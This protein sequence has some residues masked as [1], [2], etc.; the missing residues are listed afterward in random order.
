M[1]SMKVLLAAAVLGSFSFAGVAAEQVSFTPADQQQSGVV[2]A[3]GSTTLTS[4]ESQLSGK[5]TPAGAKS[6]R[7]TSISGSNNLHG[8]AVIYN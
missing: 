7:I 6:F 2:S 1:K 4:L 8:T 3:T 5:A